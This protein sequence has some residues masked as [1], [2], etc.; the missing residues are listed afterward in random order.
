MR[1]VGEYEVCKEFER[2][3]A[4]QILDTDA[5]F[6]PD[7]FFLA[8]KMGIKWMNLDERKQLWDKVANHKTITKAQRRVLEMLITEVD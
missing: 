7:S 3:A 8:A 5:T 1:V 6:A 4:E 2:S